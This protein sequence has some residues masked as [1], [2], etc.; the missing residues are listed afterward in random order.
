MVRTHSIQTVILKVRVRAAFL[1]VTSVS[2]V[3][4]LMIATFAEVLYPV[5][6]QISFA[7]AFNHILEQ[8]STTM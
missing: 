7:Q 5:N 4:V 6:G 8:D 3:T 2:V 1:S